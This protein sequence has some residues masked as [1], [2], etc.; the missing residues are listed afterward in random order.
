MYRRVMLFS[1]II[2]NPRANI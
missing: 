2:V 1:D